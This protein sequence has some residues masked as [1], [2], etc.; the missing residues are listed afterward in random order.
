MIAQALSLS[1]LVHAEQADKSGAPYAE[2]PSRVAANVQT[3]PDFATFS[4]RDRDSLICAGYLHDVVEDGP[5]FGFNYS[6]ADLV[7]MGF[8]AATA[9]IVELLSKPRNAGSGSAELDSYY[10]AIAE[11]PLARL[12]KLSDIADNTNSA[13]SAR[14]PAE[15]GNRL[16]LK[17]VHALDML[18]LS[19]AEHGWLE[20]LRQKD[21]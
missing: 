2:H 16:A 14:V 11:H 18:S 4:P 20:G 9:K 5:Q 17:Y 19:E 6:P 10:R 12:V 21:V 13:R 8:S 15:L 1:A 3:H 7:D